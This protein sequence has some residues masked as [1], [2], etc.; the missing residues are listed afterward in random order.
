VGTAASA[1]DAKTTRAPAPI[2]LSTALQKALS[3]KAS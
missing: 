3:P 1:S 2:A